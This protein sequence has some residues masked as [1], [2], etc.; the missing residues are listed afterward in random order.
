MQN[1]A[2]FYSTLIDLACK[3]CRQ[4]IQLVNHWLISRSTATNS[5]VN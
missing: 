2:T 3:I 4:T 5:A 1:E